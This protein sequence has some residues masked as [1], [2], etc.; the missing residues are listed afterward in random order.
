M[1]RIINK[2]Y[3]YI[4]LF[5]IMNI[6]YFLQYYFNSI[7]SFSII[8]LYTAYIDFSDKALDNRIQHNDKNKI[9]SIYKKVLPLVLYNL[10]I[11]SF[12]LSLFIIYFMEYMEC[13]YY[14]NRYSLV[15]FFFFRYIVDLPFYLAHRLFHSK[16]FYKYHSIHHQVKAP[17]GISAYY[18]HPFDFIFGNIL[19]IFIPFIL[20][21]PDYITLH[22]WTFSTIFNTVY[23]SH[24]GFSNLSEFHDLHHKYSRCNFGTN[25]FMDKYF[26]TK[27][28]LTQ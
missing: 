10:F 24:G 12:Y 16:Y 3:K 11:I 23:D 21:Q 17:I 15:K 9:I 5:I 8:G 14:P 22:I 25:V 19:P 6:L 20:L 27:K 13:P 1:C 18:I 26:K 7:I 28:E 4:L 2:I